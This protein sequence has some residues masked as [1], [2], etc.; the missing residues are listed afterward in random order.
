MQWQTPNIAAAQPAKDVLPLYNAEVLREGAE[1]QE[2]VFSCLSVSVALS[3]LCLHLRNIVTALLHFHPPSS[4]SICWV[5]NKKGENGALAAMAI[6]LFGAHFQDGCEWPH[7]TFNLNNPSPVRRFQ[8]ESGCHNSKLPKLL[9]H[10][11]Q[12][13]F[14]KQNT[15]RLFCVPWHWEDNPRRPDYPL[16]SVAQQLWQVS[17]TQL[18]RLR[19]LHLPGS[20]SSSEHTLDPMPQL[21][22]GLEMQFN[23]IQSV[24]HDRNGRA[25]GSAPWRTKDGSGRDGPCLLNVVMF[26]CDPWSGRCHHVAKDKANTMV[27][28]KIRRSVGS[29][30]CS[31]TRTSERSPPFRML[32][33]QNI[34]EFFT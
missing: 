31:W 9:L 10:Q 11:P 19:C 22:V 16:L 13:R 14:L 25:W 7:Y 4:S 29:L 18:G 5:I 17:S 6:C 3:L 12:P 23:T 33:V 28:L 8:G 30:W 32:A 1:G 2:P 27:Q 20:F 21:E 26:V 24:R 34:K 15:P